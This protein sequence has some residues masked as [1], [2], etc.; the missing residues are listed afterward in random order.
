MGA[1]G[2]LIGLK[3]DTLGGGITEPY[4][5]EGEENPTDEETGSV[6]NDGIEGRG[7]I[8]GAKVEGGG[9]IG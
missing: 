7:G 5:L 4:M 9:N 3:T 1:P 2:W 8:E 6:A